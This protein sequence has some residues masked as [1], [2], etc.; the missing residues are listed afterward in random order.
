M[1]RSLRRILWIVPTLVV[2]SGLLFWFISPRTSAAGGEV[3]PGAEPAPL[4]FQPSPRSVRERAEGAVHRLA[5]GADADGRAAA[6]LV[7]LGG[8]ALP[9]VLPLFDTLGPEARSRVALALA[10]V[11]RRMGTRSDEL[12]DPSGAVVFWMR[13]WQD[14]AIDFRPQIVKRAVRRLAAGTSAGRREDVLVLDTYALPELIAGLEPLASAAD[15]PRAAR[16]T[17]ALAH[18]SGVPW[19]V[20][21]QATV[22]QAGKISRDWQRWW[23]ENRTD[24]DTLDGVD[25]VFAMLTQTQYGRWAESVVYGK[26][27][28]LQSGEPVLVVAKQR[29]PLTLWLVT[30]AWLGCLLSGVGIGLWSSVQAMSDRLLATAA[31]ALAATPLSWL[32]IEAAPASAS[33]RALTGGLVMALVGGLLVARYQAAASRRE[34][35]SEHVQLRR[36]FGATPL[37]AIALSFRNASAV[38]VSLAGRELPTVLSATIVVEHALGLPGLGTVT[39]VAVAGGDVAWL[40][41]F[42]LACATLG[43]LLQV[44]SD[45]V[46]GLVHPAVARALL[47]REVRS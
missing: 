5:A 20:H 33:G 39:L 29:A 43:A 2:V 12:D 8:A 16:L 21:P 22:E 32:A 18:V 17:D 38:V 31:L 28:T 41:A 13:F 3:R 45:A 15:V 44:L 46:L 34:L 1:A 35:P 6:E 19:R 23:R 4:F 24:F 40:M 26:L 11:G 27:G 42:G 30:V 37:R 25:R 7:R 36:A 47:E 14:R 9:H 10:P